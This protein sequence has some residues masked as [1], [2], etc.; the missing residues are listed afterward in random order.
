MERT[1]SALEIKDLHV[2]VDGKEVLKGLTLTVNK[3]TVHVLMGPNGAGKSCL[4]NVLM[5]NP[6]YVITRGSIILEGG[7]INK[8]SPDQRAKRGLFLSF[9][10]P[11]EIAGVT[12]GNF[13]RTAY[14]SAKEKQLGVIEFHNL[15]KE[16]MAVLQM[17]PSF[18]RRYVNQGFS[19]GEKKRAE[20]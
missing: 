13:L 19:G 8:L 11:R 16:K 5:G 7:E 12:M 15:L 14:N 9:Q 3:G 6:K 10:Y 1:M 17:D 20:I 18:S 2:E 4:A